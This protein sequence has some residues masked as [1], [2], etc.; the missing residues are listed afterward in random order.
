MFKITILPED[1]APIGA[2]TSACMQTHATEKPAK[3]TKKY[4]EM[5]A[6]EKEII[7]TL[8]VLCFMR[9]NNKQEY[10]PTEGEIIL[11]DMAEK[12]SLI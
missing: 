1:A 3:E 9:I 8:Q 7:D 12:L 6:A 5:N 2:P 4:E 10:P 11:R